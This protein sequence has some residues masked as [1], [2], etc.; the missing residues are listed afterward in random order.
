MQKKSWFSI[1]VLVI[2]AGLLVA[3]AFAGSASSAPQ[4]KSSAAK[5][6]GT[7][8]VN[9]STTDLEFTD[10]ALEY[11]TT[12]WQV[13]YA[14]ALKLLNWKETKA[15][16]FPE[17]ATAFPRVGLGGRRYTFTIRKGLR[18]SDG[19]RVTAASFKYA[20]ARALNPKMSSPAV[21][22]L[23]DLKSVVAKGKYTLI[24]NLKKPRPDFNSI[25]SMPFF[26]AV[27]PSKTPLDPNGVKT[28]PSG[29][30]YY[31]ASRDVGRSIV[32]KRNKFYN[33]KRPHNVNQVNITAN[34]NLDTSL[35]QVKA[36]QRDYDM[37]GVPPTAH[38][39]LHSKYPKRYHVKP[40]IITDYL[41]MN[42]TYGSAG[43]NIKNHSCF[44]GYV[45]LGVRT[46]KAVNYVV[47]R[48]ASLAARGAFAGTPTNQI[49]P[50]TM[51]GFH[52]WKTEIGYPTGRPN[53]A[54][55][56]SLKPKKCNIVFYAST[57]PISVAITQ[58]IK[59]DLNKIGISSNIKLFPFAVRIAKEGH[60]GEPFDL[61]L[62]AWGADYPDPVD[63]VD[64]LLNGNNI[65]A[66]NNNNNAY[67]NNK[68]F[69]NKM[70]LAGRISNLPKRYAAW[71][72]IDRDVMK[73]QAPLA[74][75]F[76]RT[77][78][79]FTSSRVKNYSYQPI[80]AQMNFNAVSLG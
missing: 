33:G 22:F 65:A 61:D 10:P 56:R 21:A 2:G 57:S 15:Q 4:N 41:S 7:L 37:F 68:T 27:N 42:T 8:R 66:E 46:R 31:I 54:K 45:G 5:V 50:P 49:L 20:F 18:L 73:D 32:L 63:F 74:P 72:A 3:A 39:E 43:E 48:P 38:V 70:E 36:N 60:R 25:V 52:N 28:Y 59:S 6:G 12:G 62:Q 67:F 26:Q 77:V 9:L 23:G 35:L 24:L 64:I 51:P 40:G 1:A 16:L 11:E 79:E 76:F 80:Y 75:L 69:N 47:N 19:Y 58:I 44:N 53:V 30:P 78:R 13:E 17:A 71:A 29:G 34:T 55:A 14:T